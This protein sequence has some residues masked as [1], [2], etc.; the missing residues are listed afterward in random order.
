MRH[1]IYYDDHRRV[2]RN[3]GAPM[4]VWN[5]LKNQMKEDVEHLIPDARRMGGF[6]KFDL[7]WWV[8]WG[9]DALGGIIDYKPIVCPKPSIYWVSDTHL[10]YEYRLS[11]AREFDHVFCMQKRAAEEFK[12]DGIENPI[13]LPHAFEPAAYPRRVIIPKYDV[14]FVGHV[15]AP[16][17]I[18][19]LDRMFKEFPNFFFGRRLF[20]EAAQ[21]FNESKIVL[22]VSIKDDLNM[23]CMETMGSGSFLLTNELP[24]LG[25]LFKDGVHLVTYKDLDD[26][27]DKARY[28]IEHDEERQKIA[29]AGYEEAIKKHTYAHRVQT[30]L[31]AVKEKSLCPQLTAAL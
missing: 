5:V 16:N 30:I 13:W 8:D 20:E 7:H 1:A 26:A 29:A 17:R 22:N 27:V 31:N 10:G 21:K 9:E 25:E 14:C 4:Y 12:R 23:R 24:T 11:K 18:D 19:F 28:Y 3:D 15:N 6:G 2:T